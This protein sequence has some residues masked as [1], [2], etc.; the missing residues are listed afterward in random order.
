MG[1]SDVLQ[2][3]EKHKKPL[4]SVEIA[5]LLKGN[6]STVNNSIKKLYEASEIDYMKIKK[7]VGNSSRLIRYYFIVKAQS[8]RVTVNQLSLDGHLR[9]E[10]L[11]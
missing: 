5:G 1:Q 4:S 7:K 3:L 8:G 10:K 9:S 11:R 6:L 2:I